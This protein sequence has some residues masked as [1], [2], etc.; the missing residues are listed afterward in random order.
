MLEMYTNLGS[1]EMNINL[2]DIFADILPKKKKIKKVPVYEAKRILE[3]EEAQ[4][5]IDMDEVIEEAIKRAENDGIIFIDEID[6]IASSGYTAGPDVSREGVQRD[7][8]PIIEGCTVMTKYG[9]V[10]TDHILF[11]AAGAFNIAKVSDLIPELQGRFPVR[12]N[13]KPLTKEDFIRILKEPKNALT[14]QYQELLRTEGIEVKYTDEA[15][16][17]IAEVAYLINQQSED[18]G[19]RR[20]H[21]VM[22]KLFEEL[23]FKAPDLKGQQIV[24][25]EEYVKEQLK[26][27][28]N[29]YEVNKYIL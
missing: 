5:L 18:I 25:T 27:S 17:A 10:K 3:S 8:L 15:I 12:V 14:K 21:T 1:E 28:L 20:L 29:K 7:I 19:A 23:S 16:E 24:I 22:E 4:N 11:I 2:Q 13:L 9:P 26:D 6:K